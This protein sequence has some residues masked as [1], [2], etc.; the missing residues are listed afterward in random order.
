M[1]TSY[2][3]HP[4]QIRS[5]SRRVRHSRL[6]LVLRAPHE[7]KIGFEM[8][9]TAVAPSDG[10]TDERAGGK[11]EGKV[12][13]RGGREKRDFRDGCVMQIKMGTLAAHSLRAPCDYVGSWIFSGLFRV[14]GRK[15]T[16]LLVFME[17][18]TKLTEGLRKSNSQ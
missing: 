15:V 6:G 13:R 16:H 3:Y 2:K 4:F 8:S 18:H 9:P 17:L 7:I 11:G 1:R 10:R 12:E 14:N 5:G